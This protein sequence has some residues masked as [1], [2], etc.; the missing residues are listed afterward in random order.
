MIKILINV[1]DPSG[2]LSRGAFAVHGS[3]KQ[4]PSA[5]IWTEHPP[6]DAVMA[7]LNGIAGLGYNE[8]RPLL[9]AEVKKPLKESHAI[10]CENT[11]QIDK[12]LVLE[13]DMKPE[14]IA[15]HHARAIAAKFRRAIVDAVVKLRE[16]VST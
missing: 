15:D 5:Y 3:D 14:A 9:Q 2:E 1:E 7:A 4:L 13:T 10:V 12:I 8:E 11:V 16:E 6:E